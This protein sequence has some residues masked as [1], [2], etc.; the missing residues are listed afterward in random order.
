MHL[1]PGAA[2]AVT[3]VAVGYPFDTVKTRLQLRLHTTMVSCCQELVRNEGPLALYRGAAMPLAS[4]VSKRPFEFAAFEWLNGRFREIFGKNFLGGFAASSVAGSVAG[5]LGAFIGCPFSVVKIQM[6][7]SGREVHATTCSAILTIWKSTGPLG[8]Y[9][10]L[11]ASMIMQ[12]PFAACYLGTYGK[13]RD[14]LPKKPLWTAVAGGAASLAT[15]TMLQPLDTVRTMIQ[16]SATRSVEPKSLSWWP[17]VQQVVQERGALALW[18]GWG[19]A[20]LRSLPTSAASM[21]VYEWCRG[22]T[23]APPS[24]DR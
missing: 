22:L 6:Q 13:L 12:V 24:H 7:A 18:A 1:L 10:G 8:F 16:A 14:T 11:N 3:M 9:R 23:V 19:P 21:L 4:L 17:L 5:L 2:H 15:C 20:A